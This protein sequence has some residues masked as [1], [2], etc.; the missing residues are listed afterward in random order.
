MRQLRAPV[1]AVLGLAV[2]LVL[3]GACT[4]LKVADDPAADGDMTGRDDEDGAAPA[5]DGGKTDASTKDSGGGTGFGSY[6]DAATALLA[7]RT[8]GPQTSQGSTITCAEK[9]FYWLQANGA[10]HSWSTDTSATIDYAFTVPS[11]N[12]FSPSDA[13]VAVSAPNFASTDVYVAS[14]ANQPAGTMAHT[15][16][17]AA[18][19]DGVLR[20]EIDGAARRIRK[21]TKTTGLITDVV[22]SVAT[23]Q[24]VSSFGSASSSCRRT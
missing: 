15:Y 4:E 23:Q 18:T 3:L 2:S 22:A 14:A 11:T 21:W 5:A 9:R 20:I 6:A 16:N 12:F 7:L 1:V 17:A 10:L 13:L 8:E 24:P 19:P